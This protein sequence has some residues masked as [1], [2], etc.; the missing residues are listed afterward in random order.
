MSEK[1]FKKK[2][3]MPHVPKVDIR[4]L[5]IWGYIQAIKLEIASYN[6][7]VQS[8]RNSFLLLQYFPQ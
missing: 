4:P 3:R 8:T 6:I 5:W 2:M 7:T 1:T